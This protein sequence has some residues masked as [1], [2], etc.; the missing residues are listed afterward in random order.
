MVVI[1]LPKWYIKAEKD[2]EETIFKIASKND[3]PINFVE[4]SKSID[5]AKNTIL[6]SLVRIDESVDIEER[7]RLKDF[8]KEFDKTN[9]QN[10]NSESKIP[11]TEA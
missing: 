6:N 1:I 4:D 5:D 11:P 10:K 3:I 2:L 7:K 8:A 9:R